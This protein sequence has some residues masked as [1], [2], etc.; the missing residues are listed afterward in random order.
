MTSIQCGVTA[1]VKAS[2][3]ANASREEAAQY[4]KDLAH[5]LLPKLKEHVGGAR[6]QSDPHVN[7][8]GPKDD[9]IQGSIYAVSLAAPFILEDLPSDSAA[10]RAYTGRP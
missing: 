9:P 1:A 8:Q 6:L 7:I 10:Y 3:L 4:L 2:D 5:Q